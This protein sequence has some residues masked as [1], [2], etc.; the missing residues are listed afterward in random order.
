VAS[1]TPH[2]ELPR[3]NR[4]PAVPPRIRGWLAPAL[5][6]VSL[7]A[8]WLVA[9][10][11]LPP[12]LLP[13]PAEVLADLAKGLQGPMWPAIG[14]TFLESVLGCGLGAAVAIPLAMAIHRSRWADS[15]TR[16]FL[17]ATQAIPA[18]ALAPLLVLWLNYGLGAIVV[19][20]ALIVFF[21][22]LVS[23]LS[24]LTHT[25]RDIVDAARIDG[26]SSWQRLVHVELPLASPSMMAG[27]RNGFTLSVTGAVVGEMV[28]GGQGL[29]TVLVAQRNAL[30]TSG[31]FATI[32]ILALLASSLY[33][34][35]YLVERRSPTI[36]ALRHDKER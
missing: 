13:T 4:G 10:Q 32:A 9:A 33:G 23:T 12:Y 36:A 29:A 19:L 27:L 11:G 21:P 28:M 5:L 30:D 6:A 3:R 1:S 24:G 15:A 7:L 18:I 17:G 2:H 16:P 31:M 8:V 22:I 26:A 20:C 35:L 25:D 34:L 14:Q